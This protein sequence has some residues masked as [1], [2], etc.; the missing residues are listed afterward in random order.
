MDPYRSDE[1][2][3]RRE[4]NFWRL[5]QFVADQGLNTHPSKELIACL[6]NASPDVEQFRPL[7]GQLE[8]P[9]RRKRHPC[10]RTFLR[11]AMA[12]WG[13]TQAQDEDEEC[14]LLSDVTVRA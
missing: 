5:T 2:R 13:S 8:A 7:F 10:V 3:G 14:G 9:A 1:D 11:A 12:C 6:F 4:R